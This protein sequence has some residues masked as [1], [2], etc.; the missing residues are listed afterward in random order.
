MSIEATTGAVWSQNRAAYRLG[1][2]VAVQ[3]KVLITIASK[4]TS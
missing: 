4:L 1:D 2:R 3:V